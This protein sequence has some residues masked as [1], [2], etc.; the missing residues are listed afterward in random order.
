MPTRPRIAIR[1]LATARAISVTGS[2]ATFIALMVA[3]YSA[4]HSTVWMSA[5]LFLI[6][7]AQGVFTP[8]LG[9]LGD[10][11][12]RRRVMIASELCTAAVTGAM[13]SR[14]HPPRWSGSRS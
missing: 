14:A 12:D 1:R 11:V 6:I 4:T 9:A 7:G 3:V 13:R 10:A 8:L 2:E 5:A